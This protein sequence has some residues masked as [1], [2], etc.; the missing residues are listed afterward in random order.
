MLRELSLA[1]ARELNKPERYMMLRLL[2]P[3]PMLFAGTA[4]PSAVVEIASIGGLGGDAPRRVT[5][6]ACEHLPAVLG[7]SK[8]RIYVVFTDVPAGHWGLAG[9]TFG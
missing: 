8:D 9:S 6:L 1:I 5:E 4:E 2:P 7:L 3:S